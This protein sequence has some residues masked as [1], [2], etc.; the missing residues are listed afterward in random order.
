M[1]LTPIAG[2]EDDAAK[3]ADPFLWLEDVEG[4]KALD[5]VRERNKKSTDLIQSDSTYKELESDLLEILDSDQ[6]IP[7]VTKRGE[8]YYNFWRDADHP[9][10]IWRR[11][12]SDEYRKDDPE[13]DVIL[14]LDRIAKD[15]GENW[16]WAG[17]SLLRPDYE[18][19]LIDLSR[20]CADATVTREF[21]LNQR[22]FVKDG[23][24]RPEAKGGMGWIDRDTVYVQTDFGEGSMTESGYPRIAKIWKRGTPM[25]S[26]QLGNQQRGSGAVQHGAPRIL[27]RRRSDLCRRNGDRDEV[28]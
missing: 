17:A 26:A 14:D 25:D 24:S 6:R 22:E 11:T 5:W 3:S 12:T 10:G 23:F 7:G 18:V 1:N 20:G 8:F 16:V 4:D 21:D 13:W 27:H 2:A 9:R 19:A 28:R 15:E